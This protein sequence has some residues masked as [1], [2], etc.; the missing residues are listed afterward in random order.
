VKHRNVTKVERKRET[1]SDKGLKAE[2]M[3]TLGYDVIEVTDFGL[4]QREMYNEID[5][6]QEFLQRVK[7]AIHRA[8]K[9]ELASSS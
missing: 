6:V 5:R 8:N 9:T 4:P 7:Q 3:V 2:E 1:F